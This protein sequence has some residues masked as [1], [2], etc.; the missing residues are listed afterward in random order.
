MTTRT[1]YE[2]IAVES[3][4]RILTIRLNRPERLNAFTGR[5]LDELL[6]AFDRADR[7]DEVRAIIVTGSGR[8]FCAGADLDALSFDNRSAGI[9]DRAEPWRDGGGILSLR[10]FACLK[11]VIA[12]VNGDGVGIGATMI[13]PMDVRLCAETAR[14]GYVFP[15][16]GLVPEAAS[17][18]FL[19][20]VVGISRALDWTLSGRLFGAAEAREA[21]LVKEVCAADDLLP[22]ARAIAREIADDTSAVSVALTRQMMWRMLG[23]SHPMEAHRIESQ[24]LQAVGRG[25]DV[26]EGVSAFLA[27][28]RPDFRLSP[29]RDMP[30]FF[31]WWQEPSF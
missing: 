29:S 31:P 24:A 23:A 28:R 25:A 10:I 26:R 19:P 2:Q 12:A 18:W 8:A 15:R 30:D 3:A 16:R 11:P 13:L 17:T 7:D 27:K 22:R 14:F 1:R 5:M 9:A 4:E 20:R 6:D 21:G